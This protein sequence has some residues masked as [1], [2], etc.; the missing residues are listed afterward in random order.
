MNEFWRDFVK[1]DMR[2]KDRELMRSYLIQWAANMPQGWYKAFAAEMID[3]LLV[4]LEKHDLL[5]DYTVLQVKEKYG[6]LRWYTGSFEGEI[7]QE[8]WDWIE[9]Y[10]DLSERYCTVCGQLIEEVVLY[11]RV[12]ICLP[13]HTLYKGVD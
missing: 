13:C 1:E 10:E 3:E 8:Y 2:I 4:I 5:E 11:T 7:P 12:P 9:K 6:Q